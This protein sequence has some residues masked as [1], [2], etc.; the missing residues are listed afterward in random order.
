VLDAQRVGDRR[1][2]AGGAGGLAVAGRTL[3]HQVEPV[4]AGAGGR[5]DLPARGAA[6]V[7]VGVTDGRRVVHV[8]DRAAADEVDLFADQVVRR[9]VRVVREPL[10]GGA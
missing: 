9:V 1:A 8:A 4:V 6:G 10:G 7:A 2:V 3:R 5:V